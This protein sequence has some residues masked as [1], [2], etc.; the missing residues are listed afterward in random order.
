MHHHV[1]AWA[2]MMMHR[3]VHAHT[4]MGYP[5]IHIGTYM[6]VCLSTH[7]AWGTRAPPTRHSCT[8]TYIPLCTYLCVYARYPYYPPMRLGWCVRGYYE[9]VP[10]RWVRCGFRVR[11]TRVASPPPLPP[12]VLR[13]RARAQRPWGRLCASEGRLGG[14]A[15][16][17]MPLR[18]VLSPSEGLSGL[19]WALGASAG[20]EALRMA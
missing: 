12:R 8:H 2:C 11:A 17:R 4:H 1:Y 16:P 14:L 10:M 9:G 7:T 15:G 3:T 20:S 19:Q 13:V 6:H 5:P 18:G